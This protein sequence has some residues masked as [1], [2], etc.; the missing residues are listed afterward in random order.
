[1]IGDIAVYVTTVQHGQMCQCVMLVILVGVVVL[2][3]LLVVFLSYEEEGSGQGI[4]GRCR[5]TEMM[6]IEGW[7]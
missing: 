3:R 5:G 6:G 1:M 2:V 7:Y 4:G